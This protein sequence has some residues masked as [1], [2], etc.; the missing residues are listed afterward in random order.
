MVKGT[1]APINIH[2][3]LYAGTGGEGG[4]S[5]RGHR[6]RGAYNQ[7]YQFRPCLYYEGANPQGIHLSAAFLFLL[8]TENQAVGTIPLSYI[9]GPFYFF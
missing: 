7:E 5:R 2:G 9:P 6:E 1:K 8:G 4:R 3:Q